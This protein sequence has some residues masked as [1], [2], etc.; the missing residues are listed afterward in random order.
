MEL[1]EYIQIIRR[2]I[3]V[4]LAVIVVLVAAGVAIMIF[5]P[6]SYTT[7]LLINITRDSSQP[8]AD[9]KFDDFYRIQADEKFAETVVQWIANPGIESDILSGAGIGVNNL[10]LRQLSKSFH[11]EKLS[12]QSLVVTFSTPSSD[13][14]QKISASIANVISKNNAAL[15]QD[16]KENGWFEIVAHDPVVIRDAFDPFLVVIIS[17]I[18]GIFIGF[19]IVLI[20]HYLK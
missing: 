16:Q 9:Y 12:S 15:N 18:L 5:K 7:S 1:K 11:A 3:N 17:L 20:I 10:S 2:H 8:T 13:Q 6:V 4:F 19:W 14:A